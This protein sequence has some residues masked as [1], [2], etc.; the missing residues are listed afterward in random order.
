MH[1][2]RKLVVEHVYVQNSIKTPILYIRSKQFFNICQFS[3]V[4]LSCN[5]PLCFQ[6]FKTENREEKY[7]FTKKYTCG[8]LLSFII[9]F[10][11]INFFDSSFIFILEPR[12]RLHL[13][14]YLLHIWSFL[15][16]ERILNLCVHKNHTRFVHMP[17]VY[18]L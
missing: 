18:H 8:F 7:L 9:I 17:F 5:F 11:F 3:F 6:Y 1:N 4:T 16:F 13:F 2:K 10:Y 15:V 12:I 14:I